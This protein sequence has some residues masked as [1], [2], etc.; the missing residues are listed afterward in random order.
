MKVC[1]IS[2]L[3]GELPE[4][5]PCEL[6]L[7]AGDLCPGGYEMKRQPI[8]Q[9]K[10]LINVFK[11]WL[12]EIPAES[13]VGVFGNHDFVGEIAPHLVPQSLRWTLLQD[14]YAEING[15]KVFGMPWQLPFYEWAYNLP[16]EE[17]ARKCKYIPDDTDIII[18]H[19]PPWSFGDA[20]PRRITDENE[21]KWPGMEHTGSKSLTQ[22]I[23]EI[24]PQLVV[25]GH[26]HES[27]GV[28][29]PLGNDEVIIANVSLMNRE[30]DAVYPPMVF[31]IQP[32]Q[33]S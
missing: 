22:R 10:W 32:R 9:A 15:F 29:Y 23:L 20:V 28:Y 1:A 26:I 3:H 6:L 13:V 33:K 7:L 19:G 16:E 17:I 8:M 5:P 31:E 21:H 27:R 14:A 12:E 4:I 25:V 2:D 24:K 30:Y 11:P 18:S